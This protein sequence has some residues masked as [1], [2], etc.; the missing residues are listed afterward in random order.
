MT[1]HNLHSLLLMDTPDGLRLATKDAT[2][3]WVGDGTYIY[4]VVDI[5]PSVT[6][7]QVLREA[8]NTAIIWADPDDTSALHFVRYSDLGVSSLVYAY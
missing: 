2:P 5:P 1:S 8:D 3:G 6:D 4:R 7:A